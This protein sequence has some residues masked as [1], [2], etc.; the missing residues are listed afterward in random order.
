MNHFACFQT[1]H[2]SKYT[3]CNLSCLSSLILH[4]CKIHSGTCLSLLFCQPVCPWVLITIIFCCFFTTSD[5]S[6]A[7]Q[8]VK[9]PPARAGD[10]RDVGSTPGSGRSPGGGHGETLQCSCLENPMDRGAWRATVHGATKNQT[11]LKGL[12]THVPLMVTK[13]CNDEDSFILLQNCFGYF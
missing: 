9:N 3:I 13:S 12:S 2:K 6:Q 5:A 11:R 10:L 1:L 8:V 7:A 4:K